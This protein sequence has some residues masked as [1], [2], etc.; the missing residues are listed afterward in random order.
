M[1]EL[2]HSLA[3][4]DVTLLQNPIK[5]LLIVGT[6]LP[7]AWLV[8]SKLDKDASYYHLNRLGWNA[9]HMA[10][11][12][13]AVLAMFLTPIFWIGW[14]L[15]M[16]ILLGPILAYWKVR[17]AHVPEN[18][19]FYLTSEAL[20]AKLEARRA[21]KATRGA[22]ISFLDSKKQPRPVPQKEEP[23][24]PTHLLTEDLVGPAVEARAT[25]LEL[26][27]GPSGYLVAQTIDGVKMRRD[28]VA[29]DAANAVID[30]LKDIGGLDVNNRRRRQA[31]TFTL[32]SPAGRRVVSITTAGSSSGQEARLEFDRAD[33]LDKPFDSLGFLPKQLD[34][35]KPFTEKEHRHGVILLGAPPGHGLTTLGY[36]AIGRHDAYTTNIKSLEREILLRR[37]GIDHVLFDADNPDVDFATNL[38]SILRRDPDVVIVSDITDKETARTAAHH[39]QTGGPLIYIPQR[40]PGV[41]E[42]IVDWVKRV[43]DIKLAVKPLLA[44]VNG[45]LV[46]NVCPNCKQAYKPSPEQLK[47]M[48]LPDTVQQLFKAGGKVQ[49][50]NKIENC[51]VCQGIGYF[52]QTGIFEVMVLDDQ[53]R[54]LIASN[55]LQG[56]YMLCRRNG[57]IFLQEAAMRKV[58]EGVTSLEEVARVIASGGGASGGGGGG[59]GKA[60][61]PQPQPAMA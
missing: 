16:L 24:F 38:Q 61:P 26:V 8:S 43:G 39:T 50:K 6:L 40:S 49:V 36:S 27:P 22:L 9:G 13:A 47:K 37:D 44:V 12:G 52:G 46:R 23:L 2:S 17:N 28:P 4:A 7:W 33:Q 3:A 42:Q 18:K 55:D 21:A 54:K 34:A 32:N 15:G 41:K 30:Y 10:A 31:G 48:G 59:G 51:P 20:K 5:P 45:R 57:M 58:V 56:A 1:L 60:S 35:L 53:A 19:R 29:A 14:P 25:R 11:G